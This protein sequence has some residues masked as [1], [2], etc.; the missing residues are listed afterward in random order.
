M[1][2]IYKRGEIYWI[3]YFNG[4]TIQEFARTAD[5]K[6]AQKMLNEYQKSGHNG[7]FAG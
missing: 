4:R 6:K 1:G 3:K 2:S 5:E 7:W